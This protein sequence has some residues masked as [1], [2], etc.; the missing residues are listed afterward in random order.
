MGDSPKSRIL[1][2]LEG[3]GF[4]EAIAI[5]PDRLEE[6]CA[7]HPSLYW[8]FA[9]E[10][11]QAKREAN[12]LR[13]KSKAVRSDLILR[14]RKNP[15]EFGLDK[16]TEA[17]VEATYRT[18]SEYQTVEA[19]VAQAEY[20]ENILQAAVYAFNQRKDMLS[21]EVR[22]YVSNWF[23]GPES[24]RKLVAGK[25]MAEKLADAANDASAESRASVNRRRI[26]RPVSMPASM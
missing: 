15:A 13:E 10:A 5:D 26:R 16:P 1:D 2:E 17:M 8:K 20:E 9:R 7:V 21:E 4:A 25:R 23:A 3:A 22:L 24:P 6:E 11:A 14:I 19:E 18:N 12:R